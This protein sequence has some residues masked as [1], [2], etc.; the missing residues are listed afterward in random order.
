MNNKKLRWVFFPIVAC[1]LAAVVAVVAVHTW[2]R[3][4]ALRGEPGLISLVRLIARPEIYHE[5]VVRTAGVLGLDFEGTA[6]YL[7]EVDYARR[8]L[9]NSIWLTLEQEQ[10]EGYR[11]LEGRYVIVEGRF[12]K[13]RHGHFNLYVGSVDT[14]F[15]IAPIPTVEE[16]RRQATP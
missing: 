1:V 13:T 4:D 10:V 15:N 11:A 3:F 16:L 6:L 14:V 2:Q 12:S 7:S 9:P 5:R 8:L